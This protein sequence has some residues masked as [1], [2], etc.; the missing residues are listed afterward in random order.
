MLAVIFRKVEFLRNHSVNQSHSGINY[1]SSHAGEWGSGVGFST[2]RRHC[3]GCP[4]CPD[5]SGSSDPVENTREQNTAHLCSLFLLLLL[6]VLV[7]YIAQWWLLAN[8]VAHTGE[9]LAGGE[10]WWQRVCLAHCHWKS[11][12]QLNVSR[13]EQHQRPPREQNCRDS[14]TGPAETFDTKQQHSS[15]SVVV[16]T[17][18]VLIRRKSNW[19]S[20]FSLAAK[21][22]NFKTY[23][24]THQPMQSITK[25][26]YQQH[27][28]SLLAH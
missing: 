25:V 2:T 8:A 5:E 15:N 13:P 1:Q 11:L 14:G 3:K 16:L 4:Q 27:I 7:F 6:L 28:S 22:T 17:F 12:F 20:K 19:V 24:Q 26:F 18:T 9:G 21:Q 23:Y 10:S